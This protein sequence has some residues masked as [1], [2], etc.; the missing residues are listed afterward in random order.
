MWNWNAEKTAKWLIPAI[1]MPYL[2]QRWQ[3]L[4]FRDVLDNGCGPGRHGIYFANQGFDVT[5]L[6][7]SADA[8]SYFEKWAKETGVSV[9]AVRG[10]IF[11]LPFPDNAFDAIIDY[12]VSY[13]TDTAGFFRAVGELRRVVRPG[14]EIYMTLLSQSDPGF[15]S[16]SSEE[17]V[18]QYTLV[19]AGGTPHFY[20][21]KDHFERIFQ[22][23]TMAIP[24]REIRTAGLE[25]AKESTHYHLLLKKTNR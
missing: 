16:A 23:F 5:G 20:G 11:E 1:E 13:H 7:Q 22:G 12:N 8:L 17:H 25:S 9:T 6:D 18:D 19:H 15:I 2:A 3:S 21:R 14:G 10:D 24:P 4:G